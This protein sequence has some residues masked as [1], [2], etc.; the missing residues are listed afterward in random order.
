MSHWNVLVTTRNDGFRQ[1]IELMEEYGPVR[2]S[3][4]Y[5]VLTL[6][7]DDIGLMMEELRARIEADPDI[8]RLVL[9]RVVPVTHTFSFDSRQSFE[10]RAREIVVAWAPQLAGKGFHVRIHRRGFKNRL[11]SMDEERFL[12]DVLLTV[13]EEMGEPGHIAFDEA[14]LFIM[15]ETVGT[16]AGLSLWSREDMASYPFLHLD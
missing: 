6:R 11:S 1:A 2:K 9:A 5:N 10:D 7:V 14:E 4:Y 8:L 15:V 16:Q 13:L 3:D 12:D